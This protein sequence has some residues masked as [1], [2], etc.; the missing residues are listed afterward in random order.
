MR[1][2]SAMGVIWLFIRVRFQL[3]LFPS[4]LDSFPLLFPSHLSKVRTLTFSRFCFL[5]TVTES[6]T[7][8]KVNGSVGNVPSRRRTLS[9]VSILLLSLRLPFSSFDAWLIVL[10]PSFLSLPSLPSLLLSLARFVH[11]VLRPLSRRRRSV[12]ADLVRSMGSSAL[13]DLDPGGGGWEL[14]LYGTDRWDRERAEE[15]V[16]A[17]TSQLSLLLL[18]VSFVGRTKERR[19]GRR[20]EEGRK[21][22][23]RDASSFSFELS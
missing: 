19:K 18:L 2:S 12:Q 22:K 7:F 10:F 5:Q 1:S 13:C 14:G 6:P 4:N 16:E 23:K 3:S 11:S 15:S 9:F 21:E 20:V 17:G 8:P